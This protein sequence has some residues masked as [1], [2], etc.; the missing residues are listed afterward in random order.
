MLASFMPMKSRVLITYAFVYNYVEV[1]IE[2]FDTFL[3]WDPVYLLVPYGQRDKVKSLGARW[4]PIYTK[5]FVHRTEY[6]TRA[7]F[8]EW[9]LVYNINCRFI[10]SFSCFDFLIYVSVGCCK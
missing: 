3:K 2:E 4:D 7:D 9:V 1:S 5:W 8:L 10:C 6:E